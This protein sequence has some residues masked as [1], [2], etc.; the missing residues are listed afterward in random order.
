MKL[1]IYFISDNHFMIETSLD[2]ENR[3]LRL[4]SLFKSIKSTGGTLVIGGDFFDFWFDKNE[5][6]T[7]YYED[8]L[9]ELELLNQSGISIHYIAGNH[10][11]WDFGYFHKRFNANFHKGDLIIQSENQKILVT[12]GDGLLKND[13]SYRVMK[14]IIR[15]PI[16]ISLFALLPEGWGVKAAKFVSRTSEKK[17]RM[18]VIN[19]NV[20]SEIKDYHANYWEKKYNTVLVGHYHQTGISKVSSKRLIFMGDWINYFTVTR[21]DKS[22]WSQNIWEDIVE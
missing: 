20:K 5:M 2:E 14:K 21:F 15:H 17:S 4:F 22:G 7:I 18:N 6:T 13:H 11:Y 3:R 9:S 19:D 10:D 16:S 8:I 1:P 12:H